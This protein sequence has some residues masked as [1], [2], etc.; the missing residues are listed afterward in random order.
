MITSMLI[1]YAASMQLGFI[2]AGAV[3]IIRHYHYGKPEEVR[4]QV[5]VPVRVQLPEPDFHQEALEDW[6]ARFQ[7]Q[8]RNG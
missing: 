2:Y 5:P 6:D 4:V 1:L 7:K 3:A 8:M